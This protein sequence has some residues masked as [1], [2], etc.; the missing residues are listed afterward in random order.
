MT[1]ENSSRGLSPRILTALL[2]IP[3]V[4][5]IVS[6]G[7]PFFWL[8]ALALAVLS[9][10]ELEAAI[11]R[12]TASRHSPLNAPQSTLEAPT[13]YTALASHGLVSVIAYPAIIAI[14]GA[15]WQLAQSR[16]LA[17]SLV[18]LLWS[19]VWL[20]F[21][22]AVLRFAAPRKV[23]LVDLALTWLSIGYVGLWIFVPLL[24]ER[25]APWMW[26]LLLG[27]WSSDIAAYFAGR[28]LGK[29]KLTPLS[30]GKTRE[31]ALAGLLA[32]VA[33]CT[34]LGAF[35][36]IGVANGAL[37][38]AIIGCSAPMGDLVESYWK[39]EVGVKDLGTLFPGHGGVLDRCDSLIFSAFAVWLFATWRG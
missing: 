13:A 35:T 17:P 18:A 16:L 11:A 27:V 7:G 39:R 37:L 23:S 4:A 38:G 10:R 20:G 5:V 33:V 32:T 30:P 15:A 22:L 34:L 26:L 9:L 14:F 21:V 31:G 6:V 12:C 29:H 36:V 19:V 2:G 28:A 8:V 24:R 3:V 1:K 25:G